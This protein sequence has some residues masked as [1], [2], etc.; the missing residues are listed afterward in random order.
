MNYCD[1]IFS[2]LD[3]DGLTHTYTRKRG[4]EIAASLKI[5]DVESCHGFMI[6]QE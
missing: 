4:S 6:L 5:G 2:T 3:G 1:G